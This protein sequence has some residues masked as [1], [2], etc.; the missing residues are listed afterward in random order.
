LDVLPRAHD[1]AAKKRQEGIS[2]LLID[3]RSPGV[4]VRPILT[5]DGHH[6]T[7]EVFL[8]NVRAPV[9]NRIGEENKGWDY[10]KFL[11]GNERT[12]IARVGLSK[13]RLRRARALAETAIG[14]K[15]PLSRESSFR[16]RCLELEVELKALEITALRIVDRQQR[17]NDGTP[18]PA[19][20]I[21]KLR[22]AETQQSAA[23]LVAEAAGPLG[24]FDPRSAED[25]SAELG[26]TF[27]P[28][29]GASSTYF[30]SRAASIYGGA[31]EIQ[32]NIIAKAI[33]GL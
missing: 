5:I 21:L 30:F 11:L 10:A 3:M 20:S 31:S 23:E 13:G 2:F 4:T 17:R 12:G 29:I 33:L 7:N 26:E 9:A 19:S 18:D 24:A 22:G 16:R 8:D 15:G 25:F 32:K 14:P 6:H 27:G 1:P 28:V